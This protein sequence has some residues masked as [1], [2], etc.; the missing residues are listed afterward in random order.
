VVAFQAV[1]F[2]LGAVV[3]PHAQPYGLLFRRLIAGHL[4]GAPRLE[5]ARPP[6][7]AQGVG[8]VFVLTALVGVAIDSE[9]LFYIAA[10]GAL[11]ASLLNAI[12]DFCLG[13]ELYLL[14]IR[15]INLVR[16]RSGKTVEGPELVQAADLEPAVFTPESR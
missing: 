15:L 11:F 3:G 6:R 1:I 9:L 8:L 16:R 4:S 12:F 10:A 13:C 14:G 5:D 2:G 7:F